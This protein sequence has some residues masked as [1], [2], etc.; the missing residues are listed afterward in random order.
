[1]A[2]LHSGQSLQTCDM[3]SRKP[4]AL[5]SNQK[6]PRC[7]HQRRNQVF[8]SAGTDLTASRLTAHSKETGSGMR[9]KTQ[10]FLVVLPFLFP[11]CRVL[12][13]AA[14]DQ[15]EKQTVV[16]KKAGSLEIKADVYHY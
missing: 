15:P 14:A 6:E 8:V 12:N 3:T 11:A 2:P 16:Y 10:A 9:I 13:L 7:H 1:M 4:I 5:A